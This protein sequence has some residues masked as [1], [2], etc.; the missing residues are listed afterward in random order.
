MEE[1]KGN[2]KMD[3]ELPSEL[4]TGVYS[5]LQIINH[6]AT[7]FIID[8]VQMMP[9]VPKPQVR[10]RVILS[11]EHA[12]KLL[13]ALKDNIAKFEQQNGV[14]TESNNPSYQLNSMGEA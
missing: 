8:F 1:E 3:I 13:Y 11:P 2:K 9:G 5:N 12:K 4:A 14:I 7:E 10:S 6:S